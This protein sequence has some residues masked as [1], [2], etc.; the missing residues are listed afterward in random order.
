MDTSRH[1]TATLL[2]RIA[3]PSQL[4]HRVNRHQVAKA[5]LACFSPLSDIVKKDGESLDT[6]ARIASAARHISS[7][8]DKA[9]VLIEMGDRQNDRYRCRALIQTR[10]QK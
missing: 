10:D 2:A 3:V 1:L 6:L 5:Q 7:D 9:E 8:G 4:G